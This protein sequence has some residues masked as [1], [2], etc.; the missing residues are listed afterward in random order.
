M[1]SNTKQAKGS[2]LLVS[3]GCLG[4][5]ALGVFMSLR[6]GA[7]VPGGICLFFLLMGLACRFWSARATEHL[8]L[9]M[10]CP[11]TRLFPGQETTIVYEVS[12]DKL[13]PLVWLE[14]SQNGADKDCLQPDEAFERY[15]APYET[16]REN[17]TLFLR[18]SF[19]FIGSFQTLRV[20][21]QWTAMRRGMYTIDRLVARSGDGFGLAQKESTLPSAEMPMIAVYPKAV[22]VDLSMF[23]RPQWDT[24]VGNRGWMEDNTVL[25]GNREYS[26]GD[27]WKH[28]NW[29]MA[30]REQGTPINLYETIQ[31]HAMRFVLDGESFCNHEEELEGALEVLSAILIGLNNAG[32][33]CSLSVSE[34]KRFPAMTIRGD[35]M[36]SVDEMLLRI[37]G[38]DCL[39]VKDPDAEQRPDEP[40]FLPSKF[41]ADAVSRSG[42]VFLITRSGAVLPQRLMNRMP[43]GRC[44]VLCHEQPEGAERAGLRGMTLG[45]LRK[46]GSA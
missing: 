20:E 16:D 36:G 38:F 41:P 9:R 18:Q 29:R 23:L 11:R 28:I 39:C 24:N 19:S 34:S 12:N 10:V 46:G 30:A 1:K 33:G 2:S 40:V 37:A 25:K 45:S 5:L 17:P 42:S 32:I 44:T 26:P 4:L 22:D 21:S 8:T 3:W 15:A 27:N 43:M 7:A 31:P 14:L 13:L 35:G 6:L